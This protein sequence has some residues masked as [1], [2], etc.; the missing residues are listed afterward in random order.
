MNDSYLLLL[1]QCTDCITY[2]SPARADADLSFFSFNHCIFF[3][4]CFS[5]FFFISLDKQNCAKSTP[6]SGLLLFPLRWIDRRRCADCSSINIINI[7]PTTF[8]IS[9][10]DV[11]IQ[12]LLYYFNTTYNSS[13]ESLRT[14]GLDSYA[15]ASYYFLWFV[16]VCGGEK[17]TMVA[18]GW[19]I[20]SLFLSFSLCGNFGLGLAGLAGWLWPA[21]KK[22]SDSHS[23]VGLNV[24]MCLQPEKYYW[25][26]TTKIINLS[27][28]QYCTCNHVL[29]CSHQRPISKSGNYTRWEIEFTHS[30][31]CPYPTPLL[32]LLLRSLTW[33]T[34]MVAQR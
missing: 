12:S 15:L 33:T 13:T 11:H 32:L 14:R 16:E 18:R 7:V 19:L 25:F 10:F 2:H 34:I 8:A 6:D 30:R 1:L 21:R 3:S 24:F 31:G 9:N 22:T 28:F 20:C 5:S 29:T 26:D 4:G 27:P 23:A 17:E